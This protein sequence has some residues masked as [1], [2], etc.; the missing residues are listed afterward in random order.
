MILRNFCL[1]IILLFT[2]VQIWAQ[3]PVKW[4][5]ETERIED[6][7]IELTFRATIDKGWYTYSQFIGDEGPIPTTIEFE[8]SNQRIADKSTESTSDP[9]YK[10]EGFDE[11]FDMDIIK[12][13]HDFT[14]KQRIIL[15][16]HPYLSKVI[17]HT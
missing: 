7:T 1:P 16:I 14:I 9:S 13:K 3:D 5:L 15:M 4:T 12:Y 10:Y 11:M 2:A 6:K 8:S 17:S